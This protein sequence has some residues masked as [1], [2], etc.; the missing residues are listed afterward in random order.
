MI[1]I[2][3]DNPTLHTPW[4]TWV[5]LGGMFAVWVFVQHAGLNDYALARSVAWG[6]IYGG[7]ALPWAIINEWV[8]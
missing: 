5:I 4:M 3:D 7:C 1:P 8:S 2:S 6:K